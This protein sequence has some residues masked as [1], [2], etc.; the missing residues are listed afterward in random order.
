MDGT[1]DME[2][3]AFVIVC[4]GVLAFFV[5]KTSVC[6]QECASGKILEA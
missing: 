6:L 1:D 4:K 5:S 2:P 3:V